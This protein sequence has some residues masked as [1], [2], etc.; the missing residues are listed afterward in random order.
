[1]P[2]RTNEFQKLVFLVK[3][4]VGGGA[5]VTESKLLPDRITGANREVDVVIESAVGG[6]H[7]LVSIEWRDHGR[8][9]NVGWVEEMRGKHEHLRTNRLVL[10]SKSGFTREA[11]KKA[12]TYGFEA[13]ALEAVNEESVKRLLGDTGSLW[14]KTFTLTP[15]KVVIGVSQ[16]GDL[17][18]EDVPAVQDNLIYTAKGEEIG[19]VK[20][21]VETLLHF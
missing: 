5:T 19:F 8:R 14:A 21:L 16:T 12:H 15:S 9:A 18:A 2:K 3:N 10:I 6:H 11:L 7:I 17:P 4:H 20:Q 13:L 1:M